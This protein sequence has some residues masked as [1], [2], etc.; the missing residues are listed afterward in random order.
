MPHHSTH[1]RFSP[2]YWNERYIQRNTPWD[3]GITPP[4][5]LELVES[6]QLRPP[7]V[8]LDLGCGT[9]TNVNFLTRLGFTAIGVDL[10]WRA[11]ASA[12]RK[13]L[14]AGLPALFLA[15]DLAH[16]PLDGIQ[17]S[18]VLD[19]G[20]LHGLSEEKR[21]GYA[22]W[23]TSLT[24]PGALYLLYGFDQAPEGDRSGRGFAP[25][26]IAARFAPQFDL[27]WQR[28]SWQGDDPVAWYLLQRR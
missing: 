27:L 20:C 18:F 8:A 5:L 16:L 28:P 24:G 26:E 7:G 22:H 9:G 19:M 13:A 10:A 21:Q 6:G 11:V 1:E 15:G 3:T 2:D 23:L 25:G 17:A 14:A 12:R 4:E